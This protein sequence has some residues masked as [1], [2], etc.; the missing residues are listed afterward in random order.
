LFCCLL[1]ITCSES[2]RVANYEWCDVPPESKLGVLVKE[3]YVNIGDSNLQLGV[4]FVVAG[5]P[6]LLANDAAYFNTKIWAEATGENIRTKK[7][8][9]GPSFT[10]SAD[11]RVHGQVELTFSPS[12]VPTKY[13]ATVSFWSPSFMGGSEAVICLLVKFDIG[14]GGPVRL[15]REL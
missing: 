7:N 6:E 13:E 4:D 11:G 14:L 8:R 2:R 3:A 10:A 12:R 9:L 1:I 15:P 5:Q